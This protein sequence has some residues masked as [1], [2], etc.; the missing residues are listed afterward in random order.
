[1]LSKRSCVM[2]ARIDVGCR[3][4]GIPPAEPLHT[5]AYSAAQISARLGIGGTSAFCNNLM[6]PTLFAALTCTP[7]CF[8]IRKL[9]GVD[10]K[11]SALQVSLLALSV[12]VL[13]SQCCS[14]LIWPGSERS[15]LLQSL[16]EVAQGR[17]ALSPSLLTQ[18]T[19]CCDSALWT[20]M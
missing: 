18:G 6:I 3:N 15:C 17:T 20:T 13:P 12:T 16:K 1:M 4:D 9:L 19:L 5:S 10:W 11:L 2:P 8:Q 14:S 7:R